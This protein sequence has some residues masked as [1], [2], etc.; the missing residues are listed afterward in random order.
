MYRQQIYKHLIKHFVGHII[1]KYKIDPLLLNEETRQK[2]WFIKF[3]LQLQKNK[4]KTN[5]RGL[6]NNEEEEEIFKN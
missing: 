6:D 2:S 3:H 1:T 4:D 5:G